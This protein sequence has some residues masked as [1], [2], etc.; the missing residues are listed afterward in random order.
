MADTDTPRRTA[1]QLSVAL[2]GRYVVEREIGAGGMATVYLARDVRHN[3]KVALKVLKPDLGAALGPERFLAEIQVTANL[4]HPNLLPLFD[5]GEARAADGGLLLFY[6]MPFVE[7]QT[8]RERLNR[9]G[10]LPVD[11]ALRIASDIAGALDHAHRRGV[12]HRDLKP[13]NVL[14]HEGV[15]MVMDFGIALAVS[16]AGGERLTQLGLSLGTPQYMSPEQATGDRELDARSDIY[17]LGAVTYEM[18]AGAPPHTGNSVQ[19]VIA[20]VIMDRPMSVRA[21]REMVPAH[22]DAAITRALAKL[23]ADRFNTVA[24]FARALTGEHALAVRATNAPA[25]LGTMN[26]AP[27]VASSMFAGVLAKPVARR[28]AI[29]SSWLVMLG[30]AAAGGAL[31][32]LA[33]V[34]TPAPPFAK[35]P[36]AIPDSVVLPALGRAV[37]L[38][39]DGTRLA[40]VASS[41]TSTRLFGR[42]MAGVSFTPLH[43]TE[44]GRAPSFSP[45]GQSLVFVAGGR[46]MKVAAEGGAALPLADSV[47]GQPSW[48][49][50]VVVF[51][52][53]G[54]LWAVPAAGGSPRLVARPDSAHGQRAF[55]WPEMLP[56]GDNALVTIERSAGA[57]PD[58][59]HIGVVSLASGQVKDLGVV[60]TGGRFAAPD[61]LVYATAGGSLWTVPFSPRKGA[62]SG[63]KRLLAGDAHVD[64]TGAADIA[65]SASGTLVVGQRAGARAT[66]AARVSL[67]VVDHSGDIKVAGAQIGDFYSPR[68]SPDGARIALTVREH[69][70]QT[71][72]WYFEPG[73]G[74]LI[75]VTRNGVSHFPEWVDAR[76][77]VFRVNVAGVG[78]YES[79]PWDHS[80]PATTYLNAVRAAIG[81]VHNLSLG[82]TNGYLALMRNRRLSGAELH[83]DIWIA[84]MAHVDDQREVVSTKASELSPRIS[85]NGKWLAYT[86]N[87]SGAFQV[88]VQQVPGPGTRI[89]V[90]VEHGFEPVWS[91]DGKQ[92]YYISHDLL[93]SAHVDESSGFR[94]TKQDTLFSFG[95]HDFVVHPPLARG[96]ALDSYDVF[97]NGDMVVLKRGSATEQGRSS[98]VALLHWRQRLTSM[99]ASP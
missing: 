34:R 26:A 51:T 10:Q 74:Q 24:E 23:P 4:Q 55:A 43:G 77:L 33:L 20:K 28:V 8:L 35:L 96:P 13:E 98:L 79:V 75:P 82:P 42:P 85:P 30:L 44:G 11:V 25:A 6:V 46:L 21:T 7:G 15:P 17:S 80:A 78:H 14:L 49:A 56:A 19:A 68:V 29:G 93:L 86:S 69:G 54:S 87:E 3:R 12:V 83:Q 9:E 61:H 36:I 50:D 65:V 95:K 27:A 60:G 72:V 67:A 62:T 32:A 70:G 81:A 52:R 64:S 89:P 47:D 31:G 38:S 84:P 73:T 88:Y 39:P 91:R 90:S 66:D 76:R 92:L 53:R 5:S 48:S 22:V 97:A 2:A 63:E 71:D 18:L 40:V 99:V 45:D 1:E 41:G 58:S 94:V 37:A 59:N 16:N 57:S